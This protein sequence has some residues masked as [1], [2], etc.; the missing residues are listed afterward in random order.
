M[1][2]FSL[3]TKLKNWDKTSIH[4]KSLLLALSEIT[5]IVCIVQDTAHSRP[6]GVLT[7]IVLNIYAEVDLSKKVIN[8]PNQWISD[9]LSC[10]GINCSCY[11]IS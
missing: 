5:Y 8:G 4:P 11:S 9:L 6:S 1:P 3:A 7:S 10:P 2:Q